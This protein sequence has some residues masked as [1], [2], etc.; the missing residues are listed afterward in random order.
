VTN[1]F[2]MLRDRPNDGT[3]LSSEASVC[4]SAVMCLGSLTPLPA[5]PIP[6]GADL[7]SKKGWYLGLRPTEQVVTSAIIIFGAMSFST[8]TPDVAQ[9]APRVVATAAKPFHTKQGLHH[10]L[11]VTLAG[12]RDAS[13]IPVEQYLGLFEPQLKD[14]ATE[15]AAMGEITVASTPGQLTGRFLLIQSQLRTP[16]RSE[17]WD[18]LFSPLAITSDG[19][20]G[21]AD[22]DERILAVSHP[23]PITVVGETS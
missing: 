16:A 17:G 19:G 20:D 15:F 9:G 5:A 7:T 22:A 3:R 6:S 1:Y 12:A 10:R 18:R 11:L 14:Q 21:T 2:F 8:H 13:G 4:G 23:F